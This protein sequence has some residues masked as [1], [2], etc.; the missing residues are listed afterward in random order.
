MALLPPIVQLPVPQLESQGTHN[1]FRSGKL[2]AMEQG[3]WH[4]A[5]V[6]FPSAAYGHELLTFYSLINLIIFYILLWTF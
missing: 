5:G 2:V 4:T 3:Y 1:L 6:T